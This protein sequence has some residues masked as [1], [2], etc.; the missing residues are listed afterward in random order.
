[1]ED[2]LEKIRSWN[3]IY[4]LGDPN[5]TEFVNGL[6]IEVYIDNEKACIQGILLNGSAGEV[7]VAGHRNS[8]NILKLEGIHTLAVEHTNTDNKEQVE[9]IFNGRVYFNNKNR[10]WSC[11]VDDIVSETRVP[12]IVLEEFDEK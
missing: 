1:M 9:V 5:P 7:L 8:S 2:V 12:F 4:K 3:P 10:A 11:T 6:N